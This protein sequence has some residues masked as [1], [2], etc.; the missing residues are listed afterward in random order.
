MSEQAEELTIRRILIALDASPHSLAALRAAARLASSLEAELHG[1]FVE[2]INLLRAA[3]LPMA[4]ELQLPFARHVRMNPE[5]TRRQLRAQ[6][7]QARQALASICGQQQIEWAFQVLRGGVSSKV[8]EEAAK[9][10]LLCLGRISRPVMQRPGLGST[11]RAAAT[12]AQHSVLLISHGR[13]IHP[14]VVV[15]YD[16]SP[17]AEQAL[18]L[19]SRL[20]QGLGGFLSI[21]VPAEAPRSSD[22]IQQQI[23]HRLDGE[24]LVIHYRGLVGPGV[25]PL[26]SA[27]RSEKCGILVL[28]RAILSPDDV[29]ELLDAVDCP[30]LLAR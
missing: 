17:E 13:R 29:G 22:E 14:P 7:R 19:A 16:G 10:D 5:R 6:A 15:A 9:A 25:V 12:R 3:G 11:A 8:L 20:V 28:S 18:L 23:A 27:V 4:R 24:N 21:L 2:D 1:L 26:I 30:V